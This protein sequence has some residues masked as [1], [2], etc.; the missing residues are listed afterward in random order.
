VCGLG[1]QAALESEGGGG[2]ACEGAGGS[3]AFKGGGR[4]LGVRSR[5]GRPA[6]ISAGDL[7]LLRERGSCAARVIPSGF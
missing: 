6:E 7:G 3:Q 1:L 4:D 5:G 2:V